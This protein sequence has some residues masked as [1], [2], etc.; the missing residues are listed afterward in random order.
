GEACLKHASW[1]DK[2]KAD[3]MV[4]LGRAISSQ[5]EPNIKSAVK[6]FKKAQTLY[7][8][9]DLNPDT[10]EIDKDP[11]IVAHLLAAPVKIQFGAILA[12]EGK[13]KEA[14]SVYQEA[15]KLNLD[16][17]LNPDTEEID[18][19]PKIVAYLLAAPAKIQEGA[20]L[21][22]DG[23]IQKAI[24]A[25][26]EAQKLYPDIDLN[27]LTKEID[28]DPKT[29]APY[30]AAQEK[31]KQGR[32]HAGEGK[33]QKAISA[34]QEAQKLYPDID[35]N[36]KTKEI[37]KDPKT[38]APYL[39]ALEKAKKKV[40]QGRWHARKG[41]IQKAISAYQEAQKLYPDIDLNPKTKEIDKD[42]KTVAQQL[43]SE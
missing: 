11:K 17:D 43:A 5:K 38:V 27:P 21:A 22:R 19:D 39:A 10:E 30:L 36:P 13:I 1:D 33:I 32:R 29:V 20:R 42:P 12:E 25:Y 41:K 8:D 18:K 26:Q 14:I 4:R 37:D 16:I 28:K 9:I 15:Q 31:V 35:L 6:K 40:K 2:A 3:F 23:E 7:P 34:Y 24:S